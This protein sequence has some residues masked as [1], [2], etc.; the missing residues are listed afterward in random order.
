MSPSLDDCISSLYEPGNIGSS[1]GLPPTDPVNV[2]SSAVTFAGAGSLSA[3]A[4]VKNTTSVTFA[5]AGSLSIGATAQAEMSFIA[6]YLS[7]SVINSRSSDYV[8]MM[9]D[10]FVNGA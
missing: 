10:S 1:S 5:G 6:G 3:T 8:A 4:I 9:G 2:S 7:A